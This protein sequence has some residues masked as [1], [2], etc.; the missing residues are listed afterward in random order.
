MRDDLAAVRTGDP[1][2]P[3]P[4]SLQRYTAQLAALP[5]SEVP[6]SDLSD[7]VD[8]MVNEV[9]RVHVLRPDNAARVRAQLPRQASLFSLHPL[10]LARDL[11]LEMDAH[12]TVDIAAPDGT[13]RRWWLGPDGR[14]HAFHPVTFDDRTLT[15]ET[16]QQAGLLPSELRP[17]VDA[18]ELN[19]ADLS[20]LYRTSWARVQT[21]EQAVS[22]EI[23]RRGRRLALLDPKL[24][25]LF[26][27][28]RGAEAFWRAEAARLT[29]DHAAAQR[30]VQQIRARLDEVRRRL[31]E[32]QLAQA[33]VTV[34]APVV[35]EDQQAALED[36]IRERKTEQ[37]W[38]E[39]NL[40][41]RSRREQ[42]LARDLFSANARLRRA[43]EALDHIRDLAR[44]ANQEDGPELISA[45]IAAVEQR[46]GL[47]APRAAERPRG[48]IGRAATDRRFRLVRQPAG[49]SAIAEA[50]EPPPSVRVEQ[51]FAAVPSPG[52]TATRPAALL[53]APP[54][55]DDDASVIPGAPA[56]PG[57]TEFYAPL[58]EGPAA[59]LA[60][61]LIVLPDGVERPVAAR[62]ELVRQLL[63]VLGND[64]VRDRIDRD[65]VRVVVLPRGVRAAELPELAGL[66][67]L[68][69]NAEG[70]PTGQSRAVT[71]TSERVV[72]VPEENLLGED[73]G[74]PGGH[75]HPEGY[76]SVTHELAHLV[77]CFGL[78]D[79]QRDLV[80]AAY[81]ARVE[82]GS[83]APWADGPR[84]NLDGE[85]VDNYASTNPEEY[86]AQTTNAHL[87]TNHGRDTHTGR[88]RNN[89]SAWVTEHEPELAP[90]M[91][92]LYGP[93][94]D[95][96]PG[97]NPVGATRADNDMLS[98]FRDVISTLAPDSVTTVPPV[99]S[100][101][102]DDTA[103]DGEDDLTVLAED[104]AG[105]SAAA[106]GAVLFDGVRPP[107]PASA[108]A[109]PDYT[110]PGRYTPEQLAAWAK[111]WKVSRERLITLAGYE[112]FNAEAVD[113]LRRTLRVRSAANL[114]DLVETIGRIPADIAATTAR[115]GMPHPKD[116]YRLARR[117]HADP[118]H[119]ATVLGGWKTGRSAKRYAPEMASRIAH[120]HPEL[121]QHSR[122][123][124]WLFSLAAHHGLSWQD[125]QSGHI[126]FLT[127][128]VSGHVPVLTRLDHDV[129]AEVVLEHRLAP[130]D[131]PGTQAGETE[132][133][134]PVHQDAATP[135]NPA[136]PVPGTSLPPQPAEYNS[137][138]AQ[139][140][141][142]T[143][144]PGPGRSP[145]DTSEE[146]PD[147]AAQDRYG[148]AEV[149]TWAAFWR[150]PEER[151]A[152]L[153]RYGWFDAAAVEQL[154]L[155]LAEEEIG[156]LLDLIEVIGRVPSDLP[157]VAA[158]R[159]I[160][161][162]DMYALAR[163]LRV[164]PF[165]LDVVLATVRPGES[166][167]DVVTRVRGHVDH[168]YP[169][170]AQHPGG[171]AWLFALA[172]H[173][174]I[175]WVELINH[176]F[177]WR[178][179]SDGRGV[180]ILTPVDGFVVRDMVD[181]H[182]SGI[183]RPSDRPAAWESKARRAEVSGDRV[184]DLSLLAGGLD[185][186][187]PAVGEEGAVG[188]VVGDLSLLA[189]G[190]DGFV[191][192]VSGGSVDG[193]VG[194]GLG[195]GGVSG[196]SPVSG[197]SGV[198]G[199]VASEGGGGSLSVPGGGV[200]GRIRRRPVP[201]VA[202]PVPGSVGEG[203]GGPDGDDLPEAPGPGPFP[204]G[205][206]PSR[207][208]R[209]RFTDPADEIFNVLTGR[210]PEASGKPEDGH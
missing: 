102:D 25:G 6:S 210:G 94:P 202:G 196:A 127:R 7:A 134:P 84:R 152:G 80:R 90:L 129:V 169:E 72:I 69:E 114:L 47:L 172:T 27:R 77:Y 137:S 73:T 88:E 156:P 199:V 207:S 193:E 4:E 101:A 147:Y 139:P 9:N 51:S 110:V 194:S 188:S 185:G 76:S 142:A 155:T 93:Q 44:P 124:A 91:Q 132:A 145:Q 11:A 136:V 146:L 115:L 66:S 17:D 82:Q 56:T 123:H 21:F 23:G 54:V 144:A 122:G 16:A 150:V 168:Y 20:T 157:R 170:L 171:Y 60:R 57:D 167:R 87:G 203:Q 141:P 10:H 109:P 190:L 1:G 63:R 198:G 165:D 62:G 34:E 92:L 204:E 15:A 83:D 37:G 187:V 49:L 164:D 160:R 163:D 30:V 5:R 24:P 130:T 61:S 174:R 81:A 120:L 41:I 64:D 85:P 67:S 181:W 26:D 208:A 39:G 52:S 22:A 195:V 70:C 116:L 154:R 48:G 159:G 29:A 105:V 79:A 200:R 104:P 128:L 36:D 111:R 119:L 189:G 162:P 140:E 143:A 65:R 206:P 46:V 35:G 75:A 99:P 68:A 103:R 13:A 12:L 71:D 184:G 191:P 53:P 113:G 186:F 89:G 179:R 31:H 59:D 100:R 117:L 175:S 166:A 161:P 177:L 176:G 78:S 153:A 86:F 138:T 209:R 95:T 126:P 106:H 74:L 201:P 19:A 180:Q 173:H 33:R 3:E 97:A 42:S 28:A 133:P 55:G 112:W 192:P 107:T 183:P 205:Q 18:Y 38:L 50:D 151:F 14:V 135:R 108:A 148:S 131:D 8:D 158:S 125:L 178:L 149:R 121:A 32:L 45:T 58:P 96:A 98:A 40:V 182:R 197:G 118:E 43:V 2:Q